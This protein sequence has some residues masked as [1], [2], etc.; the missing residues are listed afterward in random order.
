MYSLAG[1]ESK[2]EDAHTGLPIDPLL[3]VA[4]VLESGFIDDIPT[5]DLPSWHDSASRASRRLTYGKP[6]LSVTDDG[7]S[8]AP[9]K[10]ETTRCFE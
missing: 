5:G 2:V 3:L 4:I 1:G 6:D 10:A 8:P 9:R 7:K